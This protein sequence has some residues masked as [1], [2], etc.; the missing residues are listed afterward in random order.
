MN[1]S[2]LTYLLRYLTTAKTAPAIPA[3]AATPPTAPPAIAPTPLDE[4]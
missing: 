3:I 1:E 2:I 4:P